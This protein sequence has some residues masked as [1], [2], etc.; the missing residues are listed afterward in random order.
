MTESRLNVIV[1]VL[2]ALRAR[3]VSCYGYNKET[4]P[5][6]D[7]LAATGIK[8]EKAYCTINTTD[9]SLTTIFTGM[10]PLRHGITN[11]GARVS[12]EEIDNFNRSGIKTLPEMLK[13]HGYATCCVD[14]LGR[15]HKKGYDKYSEEDAKPNAQKKFA[16]SM[17]RRYHQLPKAVRWVV[18]NVYKRFQPQQLTA[19]RYTDLAIDFLNNATE[20]FFIFLH[21][22][23]TH[24]PYQ[25]PKDIAARFRDAGK[26]TTE[27]KTIIDSIQNAEYKDYFANNLF[28]GARD[29]LDVIAKYDGAAYYV[30]QQIGRLVQ[31]LKEKG[32]FDN[33]LIIVTADHGE[34]LIEHGIYFDHHGLYQEIMHVP[35][36]MCC[37]SVITKASRIPDPIQHI[38]LFPTI[39]DLTGCKQ[40]PG[41][42]D[43]QSLRP[44]LDGT[45]YKSRD[46]IYTEEF[47]RERRT[48]ISD[49]HFKL[50]FT[51]SGEVAV[52]EI[53][54]RPHG[55]A[56]ELYDL[57]NDPAE[58]TNAASRYPDTVKQLSAEYKR[59]AAKLTA[60]ARID[61]R[62]RLKQRIQR[63]KIADRVKGKPRPESG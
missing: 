46:Y 34:S 53:C 6:I 18:R 38:D 23:G 61:E 28:Y 7:K 12:S 43:G 17:S 45:P 30:D 33:T 2:D 22:W 26:S 48:A 51:P 44:R 16:T 15:W 41:S 25:A 40:G 42:I 3:N 56:V 39:L 55:D 24:I 9:P 62:Q 20:P 54:G 63:S 32:I 14:W 52:C 35:L 29:P 19:E 37:P 59:L 1:M 8:F 11:H 13:N 31:S 5:N 27:I 21:Y 57:A 60:G 50:I 4:T 47:N 36:V 58:T 49:G 10:F